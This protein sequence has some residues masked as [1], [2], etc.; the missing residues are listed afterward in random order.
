MK[1]AYLGYW[2]G[3]VAIGAVL[4]GITTPSEAQDLSF[5]RGQKLNHQLSICLD[6]K[7]ALAILEADEKD[8]FAAA[9]AI[10]EAAPK[11]ATLPVQ[12]A[13]VGKV[14]KSAKVKRGEKTVTA[15]V[16]EIVNDGEVIAYFFTTATVD[17]RNS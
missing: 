5:I 4:L 16:V 6:K 11:C 17:E 8:G 10:W 12:G 15:R 2:F 1:R 13:L 7:D 14:V 9:S 3:V